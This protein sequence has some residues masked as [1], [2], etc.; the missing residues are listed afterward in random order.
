MSGEELSAGL[1]RVRHQTELLLFHL[2]TQHVHLSRGSLRWLQY[3]NAAIEPLLEGLRFEILALN[4]ESVSLASLWGGS[5]A[6][7]L[8]ALIALAPAGVWSELFEDHRCALVDLAHQIHDSRNQNLHALDAVG[9]E[10]P[11]LMDGCETD[12]AALLAVQANI[13]RAVELL[14]QS[15]LPQLDEFLGLAGS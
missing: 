8:P 9:A 4:V 7:G 14:A 3:T 15:A 1:W 11:T 13:N 10:I 5:A 12:G 6:A 2:E